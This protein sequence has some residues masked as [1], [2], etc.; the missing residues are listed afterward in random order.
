V[1]SGAIA[2][3]SGTNWLLVTVNGSE[4]NPATTDQAGYPDKPC[5]SVTICDPSNP[6]TCQLVSDILLDTG[7][8]GLRIFYSALNVSGLVLTPVASG[9]GSLAECVTYADNTSDWGYVA[10]ANVHLGGELALSVPIQVID[11]PSL[12]AIPGSCT[13]PHT[14]PGPGGAI[15]AF[16]NGVLGVGPLVYDCGS[17]CTAN[18]SALNPVNYYTCVGGSCTLSTAALVSQVQN[19]VTFLPDNNGLIV[20][21]PGVPAAGLPSVNGY[22]VFGIGTQANNVPSGVTAYGL[23]Q[24]GEFATSFNGPPFVAAIVDTG[25]NGFLFSDPTLPTSGGWFNPSSSLCLS[26]TIEGASGVPASVVA[27]QIASLASL[28]ASGWVF[29]NIGA[30]GQAGF[31]DWG[32]PFFL[33]RNV[34]IGINGRGGSTLGAGPF[35]AF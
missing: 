30:S 35:V 4:C 9:G 11:P 2:Q 26:A 14:G 25:T 23:N 13:S 20:E 18:P 29:S 15:P 10:L 17:A 22:V 33:G 1:G 3:P 8:F 19:P 5:V 34:Y 16:Y 24:F 31:F 12:G 6:G 7:S 27:F 21:L 32:L 28:S